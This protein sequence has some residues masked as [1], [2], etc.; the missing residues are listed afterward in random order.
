[1]RYKRTPELPEE[2]INQKLEARGSNG[3]A[4]VVAGIVA[5]HFDGVLSDC[6]VDSLF[7]ARDHVFEVGVQ[8]LTP[9]FGVRRVDIIRG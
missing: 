7:Y 9:G 6:I 2:H 5:S 1:M 3:H 4:L 8:V